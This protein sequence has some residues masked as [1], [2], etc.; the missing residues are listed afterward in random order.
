MSDRINYQYSQETSHHN[1]PRLLLGLAQAQIPY[2]LLG[3]NTTVVHP[4]EPPS[5][6]IEVL[7]SA[8]GFAKFCQVFVGQRFVQLETDCQRVFWDSRTGLTLRVCLLEE[9]VDDDDRGTAVGAGTSVDPS[10]RALPDWVDV[11][12]KIV[13]SQNFHRIFRHCPDQSLS[14]SGYSV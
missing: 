5:L 6:V 9:W 14:V 8:L 13:S 3:Q 4:Q 10:S 7:L 11:M 2:R 1:L 12:A